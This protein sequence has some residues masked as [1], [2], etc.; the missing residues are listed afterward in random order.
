MTQF[1]LHNHQSAI[2]KNEIRR[3]LFLKCAFFHHYKSY[4]IRLTGNPCFFCI[5]ATNGTKESN[6]R[7]HD[8]HFVILLISLKLLILLKL[9]K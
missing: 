2:N 8:L 3:N 4:C 5:T 1:N 7:H 9:R 6:L